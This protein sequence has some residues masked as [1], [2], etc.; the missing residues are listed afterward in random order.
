VQTTMSRVERVR[1]MSGFFLRRVP[2][3]CRALDP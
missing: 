1:C 2:D 3:R